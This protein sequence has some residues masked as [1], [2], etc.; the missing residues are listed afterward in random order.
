[1]SEETR[2]VEA[3]L[4]RE[5]R[6]RWR[7]A[8]RCSFGWPQ[9]LACA[10]RLEDGTPFP[11]LYWLSCP[12]LVEEVA[13]IES[14]GAA[15]EWS[16]RLSKDPSLRMAMLATDAQYR[17]ARVMEG[18]GDD[19]CSLV[20]VAGQRDP[21]ATK[22]VHAHVATTLAGL[23]DPIG[24]SVVRRVERECDCDR[25]SLLLSRDIASDGAGA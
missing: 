25:C 22:C 24:D 9:V 20:G 2:V 19:P 14:E 7:V 1:M 8:R 3:Q 12:H 11:T 10:P 23:P 21:F 6:G 13:V 4:G 5:P 17:A 15:D 16:E 18:R